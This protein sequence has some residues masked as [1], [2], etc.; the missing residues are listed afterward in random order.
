MAKGDNY[1]VQAEVYRS[2]RLSV[3][4]L[5]Q[6]DA[7]AYT[8]LTHAHRQELEAVDIYVP[9]DVDD[10]LRKIKYSSPEGSEDYGIWEG[11]Q[12]VGGIDL[13][14]E[15][16]RDPNEPKIAW[17][18]YWIDKTHQGKGIAKEAVKGIVD[19]AFG[20]LGFAI[21]KASVKSDNLASQ[22]TL[23]ANGFVHTSTHPKTGSFTYTLEKP[24]S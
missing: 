9:S 2:D 3:R 20:S 8:E 24:G 4:P 17:I 5:T 16:N 15:V 7:P 6:V 13:F 14:S 12:L 19:H 18:S 10:T 1:P 21:I 11:E 23:E 22:R